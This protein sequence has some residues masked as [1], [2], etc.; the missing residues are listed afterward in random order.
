MGSRGQVF[1]LGAEPTLVGRSLGQ[2]GALEQEQAKLLA[3]L[4]SRRGAPLSF[5]E[6]KAAGVEF[7]AS[8]V[9]ELELSGLPVERCRL[10]ASDSRAVGVRLVGASDFQRQPVVGLRAAAGRPRIRKGPDVG[11]PPFRYWAALIV[12]VVAVA[13]GELGGGWQARPATSGGH[14]PIASSRAGGASGSRVPTRRNRSGRKARADPVSPALAG[15]LESRGHELLEAGD[16]IAAVPVL[17]R[18][19]SATGESLAS[20]RRPVTEACLTY[21]YALYD[22]GRSLQLA[23]HD[24]A[25]VAVLERRVQ[26]DDQQPAVAAELAL[27]R[28]AAH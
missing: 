1:R 14:R 17:E 21:A 26:I 25:A 6:L 9:S 3:L 23:G 15:H 2:P 22:L 13:L 8:V 16:Y 27:A 5:A 19:V 4:R 12:I 18:A 24:D 28:E 20:C 7:P 10:D 11:L